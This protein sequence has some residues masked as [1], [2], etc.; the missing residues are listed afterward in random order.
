MFDVDL[1]F[2]M[3][4][5]YVDCSGR[6]DDILHHDIVHPI[7]QNIAP[8]NAPNVDNNRGIC[9]GKANGLLISNPLNC[10]A[11]T[12]CN[13]NLATERNCPDGQLFEPN[14]K[15]C[16]AQNLVNCFRRGQGNTVRPEIPTPLP[17]PNE[18]LVSALLSKSII[19][20][21]LLNCLT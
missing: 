3:P 4:E 8:P 11:F 21:I 10:Q 19:N 1:F 17:L 16:L 20:F 6:G 5:E 18:Q 7:P 9:W 12:E 15:Q 2:C 14:V 13:Y